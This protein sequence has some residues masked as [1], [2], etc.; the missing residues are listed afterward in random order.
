M[1]TQYL[2]KQYQYQVYLWLLQRS[3]LFTIEEVPTHR[4]YSN[5]WVI[6][7]IYCMYIIDVK[8]PPQMLA[9]ARALDCM[10]MDFPPTFPTHQYFPKMEWIYCN[11][12]LSS[13]EVFCCMWTE[14]SHC[15]ISYRAGAWHYRIFPDFLNS[16]FKMASKTEGKAK[17]IACSK[18][19]I[20][21][22]ITP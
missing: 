9:N 7:N 20:K 6:Y 8:S 13:L 2:T 14:T 15:L 3:N 18:N 16:G 5:N 17:V 4:L 21:G 12:N 22:Q 10:L 1:I 19:D 11:V